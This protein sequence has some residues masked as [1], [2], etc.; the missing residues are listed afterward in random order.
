M[1]ESVGSVIAEFSGIRRSADTERIH[2]QNYG[3]SHFVLLVS[4]NVFNYDRFF[5]G[6]CSETVMLRLKSAAACCQDASSAA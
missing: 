1:A 6:F 2:H 3:A 4:G 5:T